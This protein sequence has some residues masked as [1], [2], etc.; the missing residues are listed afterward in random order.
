[1]RL[2]VLPGLG[3]LI[4][5][6]IIV[7]DR[8]VLDPFPHVEPLLPGINRMSIDAQV[9][10]RPP[11][12]GPCLLPFR[13]PHLLAGNEPKLARLR[14][15]NVPVAHEDEAA[16]AAASTEEEVQL[17]VVA[18]VVAEARE[19]VVGGRQKR[20]V[21]GGRRG[22]DV[23]EAGLVAY[24]AVAS[25]DSVHRQAVERAGVRL[26]REGE[27]HG[28]FDGAAVAGT[29]ERPSTRFGISVHFY[30]RRIELCLPQSKPLFFVGRP[31]SSVITLRLR[32]V[33]QQIFSFGRASA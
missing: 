21:V 9:A 10:P 4:R 19:W 6:E 33:G 22:A 28:V 17:P 7:H 14:I 15:D 32:S 25:V 12:V 1:M 8:F 5:Q 11:R 20:K 29:L 13:S 3:F 23:H 31:Y 18:L 16:D 27:V 24:L 26:A 30:E 2:P